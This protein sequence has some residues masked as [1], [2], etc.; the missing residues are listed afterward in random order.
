MSFIVH[1]ALRYD[2]KFGFSIQKNH[3]FWHHS[4]KKLAFR[5]FFECRT[6]FNDYDFKTSIIFVVLKLD[7]H[8]KDICK[9]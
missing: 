2:I 4:G 5:N 7:G 3:A 6:Y 8:Y 1:H 9:Y